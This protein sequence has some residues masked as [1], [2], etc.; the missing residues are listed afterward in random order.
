MFRYSVI[1][2]FAFLLINWGCGGGEDKPTDKPEKEQS[3]KETDKDDDYE[4][5]GIKKIDDF[6]EE[7]KDMQKDMEEGKEVEPVDFRELK[8][9]LPE[10]IGELKR[11]SA[12]GEKTNSFG[13]FVSKTEGK[14]EFVVESDSEQ[15]SERNDRLKIEITDLGNMKGWGGFAAFAWTFA[16]IDKETDTGYEKTTT[17]KGHK[18]YEKYNTRNSS[19]KIE[20]LV[21]KR[22]MVSVEGNNVAMDLIKEALDEIDIGRLEELKDEGVSYNKEKNAE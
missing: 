22:Y 21:A 2:L 14:Y 15:K 8:A 13:I 17:Y 10:E 20:V 4:K 9:L 19:G 18:A 3:S 1:L 16:E 12:S 11:V 7:M 5:T 6:V